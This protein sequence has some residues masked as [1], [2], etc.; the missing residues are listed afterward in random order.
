VH[1]ADYFFLD[2]VGQFDGMRAAGELLEWAEVHGNFYGT[3]R[4][5]V[6]EALA[7]GRDVLFDIDWQGTQ[8][9]R[10]TLPDDVVTVFVLPPRAA[11]LKSRLE[12]RAEDT[13]PVIARRLANAGIEIPH[14]VEYDYVVVNDDLN[15][16]Y[17]QLH[18]ILTAER[19]KRTRRP[20]L[21]G[22]VD[23]LLAELKTLVR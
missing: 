13:P 22:F 12:R 19:L 8:Q 10:A 21:A 18:C 1:A 3:P 20:D 6:E 9:L 4:R 2:S 23:G 14:W 7:Q 5:P 17:E 16:G 11:E 15:Q